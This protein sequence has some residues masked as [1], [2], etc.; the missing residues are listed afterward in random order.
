M[1]PKIPTSQN[2]PRRKLSRNFSRPCAAAAVAAGRRKESG[3]GWSGVFLFNG[4]WFLPSEQPVS[5]PPPLSQR[6]PAAFCSPTG[7]V[8]EL[9]A[10]A[11]A[12]V[13]ASE[14]WTAICTYGWIVAGKGSGLQGGT[15]PSQ[16]LVK[17]GG[18]ACYTP[19]PRQNNHATFRVAAV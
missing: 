2:V 17:D 6:T 16:E 5:P 18:K 1:E 11:T 12:V 3:R 10:A 7:L 14:L 15:R 19:P 9:S 8:G 4:S 13:T